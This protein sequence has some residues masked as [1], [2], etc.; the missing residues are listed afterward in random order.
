MILIDSQK[1]AIRL[2]AD[3]SVSVLNYNNL[4]V[5]ATGEYDACAL[6][7][8]VENPQNLLPY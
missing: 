6:S 1:N 2:V 5:S 3:M 4:E 8:Q 7:L